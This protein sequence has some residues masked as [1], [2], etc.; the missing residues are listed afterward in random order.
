MSV[1]RTITALASSVIDLCYPG[2]C[3][4]CSDATNDARD[5]LCAG[6]DEK[7]AQLE[8][9]G[10]CEPCGMPLAEYGAPCPYCHGKGVPH[11][12][13]VA[14][15]GIFEDPIKHLV[16]RMKYHGRWTIADFLADRIVAHEPAKAI[17]HETDVIVPI[18]LH[19]LRHVQRGYN[20]AEL[21]ARRIAKRCRIKLARPLVRLRYTEMQTQ[22]HSHERRVENLRN[23]F[24]LASGR[25]IEGKHVVVVDDVMTTGATLQSAARELERAKPASLSV[26]TVAIADPRHA[27]FQSI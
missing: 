12:E 15:L 16:H 21:L 24:A 10:A 17:L 22:L 25:A 18:P 8:R 2:R 7:L 9:A 1:V 4:I 23:A 5:M 6:C 27:G 11:Y 19:P 3:E 14:R 13:R 20:Q 26:I